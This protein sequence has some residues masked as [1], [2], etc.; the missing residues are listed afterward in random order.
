MINLREKVL[1]RTLNDQT[2][3][4]WAAFLEVIQS[5]SDKY[6]P[7][8]VQGGGERQPV[9]GLCKILRRQILFVPGKQ[10]ARLFAKG[11]SGRGS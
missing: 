9:L 6:P 3:T 10:H 2:I 4:R 8:A 7:L 1:L 11:L 5:L